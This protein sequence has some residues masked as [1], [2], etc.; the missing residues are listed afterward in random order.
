[1]LACAVASGAGLCGGSGAGLCGVASGGGGGR[2]TPSEVRR[3]TLSPTC[4]C[5]VRLNIISTLHE[6]S[7]VL[8]AEQLSHS[9][10]PAIT[11][12]AQDR[13]W[14]VRMAIIEYMPLLAAQLGAAFFDDKLSAMCIGWLRDW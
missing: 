11:D 14:R 13:Q 7:T 4:L 5:Q 6:A 9:L 10:L 2:D 3:C 12:L 1:V 8:G